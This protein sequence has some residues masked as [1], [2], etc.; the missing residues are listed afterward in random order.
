MVKQVLSFLSLFSLLVH[1]ATCTL[2]YETKNLIRENPKK[3]GIYLGGYHYSFC[4]VLKDNRDIHCT[5]VVFD[6]LKNY[7]CVTLVT[8]VQS[9]HLLEEN[10]LSIT[11]IPV[12]DFQRFS[13]LFSKILQI[14]KKVDSVQYVFVFCHDISNFTS[15]YKPETLAEF[16]WNQGAR[17][18]SFLGHRN[19]IWFEFHYDNGSKESSWVAIEEIQ[20]KH[21][22]YREK[23][24]KFMEEGLVLITSHAHF[25]EL[26]RY[27][28][29]ADKNLVALLKN[30]FG[31]SVKI[32]LVY[33][34]EFNLRHIIGHINH[35]KNA[36][37]IITQPLTSN[38]IPPEYGNRVTYTYPHIMDNI[39]ALVPKPKPI[40]K[41]KHIFH[42]IRFKYMVYLIISSLVFYYLERILHKVEHPN[43]LYQYLFAFLKVPL[44]MF[45]RRRSLLKTGWLMASLFI[46]ILYENASLNA[47]LTKTFE[48]KITGIKDFIHTDLPIYSCDKLDLD[49][50]VQMTTINRMSKL[51]LAN[52]GD[53]VFLVSSV[54]AEILVDA[55]SSGD[56][57]NYEI[58][59]D[60]IIPTYGTYICT[61][62]SPYL[63]IIH[64]TALT[65]REAGLL[66]LKTMKT[67]GINVKE[68]VLTFEHFIGMF[69]IL[70]CGYV[71]SI[72]AFLYE[73]RR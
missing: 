41:W 50:P 13:E 64:E 23:S 4:N 15:Q 66:H 67:K 1:F 36:C 5:N 63:D 51:I 35:T 52:K 37:C 44:S 60:V 56:H 53:S 27:E 55:F 6:F 12:G 45:I 24:I 59:P 2:Y 49:I 48:N 68:T 16:I 57:F 11:I 43:V 18:F 71:I 54:F 42:I 65:V 72:F 20:I 32:I 47:I 29:L 9:I 22:R 61:K 28:H 8:S 38:K 69:I 46:G 30:K 3:S 17:G 21:E 62:R 14:R 26:V 70:L 7:R 58:M 39:V 31:S 19:H 73:I 33:M 34:D 10:R 25:M 40:A